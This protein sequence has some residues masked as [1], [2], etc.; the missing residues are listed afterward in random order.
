MGKGSIA[1]VLKYDELPKIL[2]ETVRNI[3]LSSVLFKE[4]SGR[5]G[6][7]GAGNFTKMTMLPALKKAKANF[8]IIASANG[9]TST[10]LGKKFGFQKCTSDY[11]EILKDPEVDLVMI[12][13]RHNQHAK[14]VLECLEQNKK[15]FVEKPLAITQNELDE[16]K[17]YVIKN[18]PSSYIH[19][20]YNR[21]YSPY[22]VKAKSLIGNSN[23]PL[24][25]IATMNAGYI[26]ADSWVHD[27][28]VGGGRIIGEACHYID[29]MMYF[30]G[31]KVKTVQMSALGN[32][33]SES[34]DNAIITLHFENGSQGVINY[35]SNGSKA[36]AKERIEVY[37]QEKVVILDNF[38]KLEAY[39]VKGFS[40]KKGA[41]DKG[42]QLQF[43]QLLERIKNGGQPLIPFDDIYNSTRASLAAIE[44][45]MTGQKISL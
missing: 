34:T 24:N 8:R 42:H 13:T 36:Y 21:R 17:E 14:M 25:M 41:Q 35:F 32:N 27:M 22:S 44:S 15:V 19:V 1:S 39:G 7:I 43:S 26:P 9:M 3:N 30:C 18:P 40:S 10:A 38:R 12:T 37:F 5:I 20:G 4:S 11:K 31:S 45:L 23:V 33:P 2:P 16:I 6:I 29:L 28:K